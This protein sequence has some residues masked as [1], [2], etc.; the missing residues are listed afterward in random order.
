[1]M[2]KRNVKV[3]LLHACKQILKNRVE[4][5]GDDKYLSPLKDFME[6]LNQAIEEALVFYERPSGKPIPDTMCKATKVTLDDEYLVLDYYIT[7]E[8]LM[9]TF[10]IDM[11]ALF[12][13]DFN[14]AGFIELMNNHT[15]DDFVSMATVDDMTGLLIARVY[16]TSIVFLTMQ[17]G[18][19]NLKNY[20]K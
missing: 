11:F 7:L 13:G 2:N 4:Q 8:G 15:E 12:V 5:V 9:N 17:R 3:D 20:F 18:Y 16:L 19:L 1:M 6:L 10:D 14:P